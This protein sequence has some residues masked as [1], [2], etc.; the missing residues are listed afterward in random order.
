MAKLITGRAGSGKTAVANELVRR[1]IEAYDTDAI[2]GLAVWY[3]THT[4]S[5]VQLDG[6]GFVDIDRYKWI[7]NEGILK[8]YINEHPAAYLCGGADNDFAFEELFDQHF[9]LEVSA[10]TQINRLINRTG[11]DYAQDPAMHEMVVARE[12]QHVQIARDIGATIIDAEQPLQTVVD[13]ILNYP[14]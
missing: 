8:K 10:P 12:Q 6:G 4:K 2:P 3:D 9:V 13:Q 14:Q 5:T 11:N 1:G 7:W